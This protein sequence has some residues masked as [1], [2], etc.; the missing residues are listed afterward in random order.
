MATFSQI[1]FERRGAIGY[2]TL[3][4]PEKRNAQ[5]LEMWQEL[6][7]L[8]QRLL[9]EPGELAVVVVAGAGGCFSS[10]VDTTLLTS[11]ALLTGSIDGKTIQEAFSWLR[12]SQ[13][14]SIA[15]I[16]KCAIGAGLELALWCDLRLAAEGTIFSLP[17]IGFGIIPDLGGC[18]L[19][20]EVCGYGR[21]IELIMT[22]RRFGAVEA[23]QL[24]IV[25]EV[26]AVD[27]LPRRVEELA[28]LLARR[29]LTALRGAKRATL[30]AL[31]DTASSLAVSLDV[32][33]ECFQSLAAR[34][35]PRPPR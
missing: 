1:A 2:L 12:A 16:E 10:G 5:T 19:L 4:R 32:I 11:G 14:I 20:A 6:R 15:T 21:A 25:N 24:G 18:S 26:V 13:F 23:L 17:E 8:G 34:Q 31:P 7:Q 33:T 3:Q 9:A 35:E 28:G 30:A 29:S 22:A 27:Q